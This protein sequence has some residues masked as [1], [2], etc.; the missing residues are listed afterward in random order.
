MDAPIPAV[1]QPAAARQSASG[2]GVA[3]ESDAAAAAL[4]ALDS[5]KR[6]L[7]YALLLGLSRGEA[8]A[9]LQRTAGL[10]PALTEL[11]A[12]AARAGAWPLRGLTVPAA[13]A[14]RVPRSVGQ[15][16][17]AEHR[18]LRAASAARGKAG[19]WPR[20][21]SQSASHDNI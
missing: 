3:R 1:Q 11:G 16:G 4:A 12:W 18:V 2:C 8:V 21:R 10:Q 9:Y 14:S 5:T 15:A 6:L 20:R 7:E 13:R 17:R 19:A